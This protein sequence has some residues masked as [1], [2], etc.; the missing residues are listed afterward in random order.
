MSDQSWRHWIER[1]ASLRGRRE[2]DA[3]KSP[4]AHRMS[5]DG[6][7]SAGRVVAARGNHGQR[8]PWQ[9]RPQTIAGSDSGDAARRCAS[10][11]GLQAEAAC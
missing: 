6:S 11:T 5:R 9:Y 1:P 8:A 4:N 7:L 10:G 3:G 2:D